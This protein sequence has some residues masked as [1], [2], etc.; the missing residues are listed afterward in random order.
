MVDDDILVF[1]TT[2]PV[3]LAFTFIPDTE[4]HV[5]YNHIF[6]SYRYWITGNANSLSRSCLSGNCEVAVRNIQ[7][8]I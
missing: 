4:T 2:E 6:C 7:V 1:C 3:R 8:T 5:T